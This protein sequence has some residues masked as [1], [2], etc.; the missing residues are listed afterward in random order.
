MKWL[1]A[2]LPNDPD[3]ANVAAATHSKVL[4]IPT[5]VIGREY[6]SFSVA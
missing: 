3:L 5:V 6:A 1:I 2:G 4:Q